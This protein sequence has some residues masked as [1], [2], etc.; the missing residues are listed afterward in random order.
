MQCPSCGADSMDAGDPGSFQCAVCGFVVLPSHSEES[1]PDGEEDSGADMEVQEEAQSLEEGWYDE[2]LEELASQ[3]SHRLS[4]SEM[5]DE[6][7][8][9]SSAELVL[10]PQTPPP[11][12]PQGMLEEERHVPLDAE[13]TV[14]DTPVVAR[15]FPLRVLLWNIA[16]LG[17]GPS[18][19]APVRKPWTVSA[20]AHVIRAANPDVVTI[21]ELKKRGGPR[22]V[23]PKKPSRWS[24]TRGARRVAR[25]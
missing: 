8:R 25:S 5:R 14:S 12:E 17:G 3:E 18:G 4:T 6:T 21:L 23:E 15:S 22:L 24:S 2:L 13:T 19:T 1:T 16:D 7:L 20:L 10:P 11:E 9:A